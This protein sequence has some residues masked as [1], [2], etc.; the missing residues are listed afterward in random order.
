MNEDA[1]IR[2]PIQA[3]DT[4]WAASLAKRLANMGLRP[5]HIS[6]LSVVFACA[7]GGCLLF[8][9]RVSLPIAVLLYVMAAFA[10][11]LRLL[12]N[13]FDGM[14]AIEGG[15]K[16][17]SGEIFNDMPDRIA[18]PI[19]LI[20]AGYSIQ[21]IEW[22]HELGWLAGILSVITAYVRVLGGSTGATQYFLGPMAKQHRMAIMTLAFIL[23]AMG[24]RW[25]YHNYVMAAALGIISLGCMITLIRRTVKIVRELE[26]K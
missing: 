5:N 3:R 11:Q 9:P 14:V 1:N 25:N 22:S 10:V 7:A 26:S 17:K 8:V 18:D 6:V 16:T 15:F 24:L 19:I 13:L 2:R 21:S 4:G 12:C 20:C 23:A